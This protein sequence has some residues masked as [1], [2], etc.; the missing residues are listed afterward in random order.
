MNH[1]EHGG[2][3]GHGMEKRL[4]L[5]SRKCLLSGLRALCVFVVKIRI[6]CKTADADRPA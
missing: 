3:K 6:H 4:D 5:G 1:R 2:R